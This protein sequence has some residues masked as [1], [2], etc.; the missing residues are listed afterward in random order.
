MGLVLFTDTDT[1][2]T[3]E[4]AKEYGYHLVSMPYSINGETFFPCESY[5][6]FG[7][8]EVKEYYDQLRNGVIP[9]TSAVTK[10]RFVEY[11][12]PHFANGDDIFFVHF[13]RQLSGA[14]DNMDKALEELKVKYPERKLY[15]L[16]TKAVTT[17]AY[18]IVREVGDLFKAG[19]TPE[20]VLKW[21][22]TEIY[23]YTGYLFVDNISFFRRSGRVKGLAAAMGT[24][25]GIR[26]II[27]F[28][29]EGKMV[30][31]GKAVGRNKAIDYL[32]DK[33]RTL[34][35]NVKDY[36]IVLGH[37][38][39]LPIVETIKQRIEE[40]Y[41]TDLNIEI[42]PANPTLGAHSGPDGV[43]VAFHSTAR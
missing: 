42:V 4:V 5:D 19:K 34:G 28:D 16:D 39:A 13:S 21:G 8:K 24:I 2:M 31:T 10:E 1:D 41:G 32:M 18:L 26:P 29:N 27:S 6:T 30:N 35:D 3:L 20:E 22:E 43:C 15:E 14:F 37:T 38:D 36:R 11:F 33:M 25:V 12:E 7:P 23:H 17:L 9:T 40:E